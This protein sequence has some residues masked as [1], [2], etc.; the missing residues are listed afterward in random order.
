M[1]RSDPQRPWV[2]PAASVSLRRPTTRLVAAKLPGSDP[3]L[4]TAIVGSN[5]TL[6]PMMKP[7]SFR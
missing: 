3:G 6:L 2:T 7:D 5:D 1:A 4:M